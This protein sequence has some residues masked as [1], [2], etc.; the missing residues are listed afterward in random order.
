M[1]TG[2]ET[3]VDIENCGKIKIWVNRDGTVHVLGAREVRAH[4]PI[5]LDGSNTRFTASGDQQP[6]TVRAALRDIGPNEL[7]VE[8]MSAELFAPADTPK[9]VTHLPVGP[10]D[11][12]VVVNAFSRQ[13]GKEVFQELRRVCV[14]QQ[15]AA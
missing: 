2:F 10:Q 11:F 8:L 4:F 5:A 3:T 9:L 14:A 1:L 6:I 7:T 15:G 13:S 12:D